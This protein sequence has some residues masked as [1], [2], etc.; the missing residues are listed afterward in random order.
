[1]WVDQARRLLIRQTT[2]PVHWREECDL[3]GA[4]VR[5]VVIA[6][7]SRRAKFPDRLCLA[8]SAGLTCRRS[9]CRWRPIR[10]HVAPAASAS[11]TT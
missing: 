5:W 9:R 11:P 4:M 8:W 7:G 1:M 2:Y 6:G 3:C 10:H